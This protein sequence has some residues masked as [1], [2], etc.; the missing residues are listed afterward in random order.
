MEQSNQKPN[1]Y[2]ATRNIKKLQ[3]SIF[4]SLRSIYE[5]SIFVSEIS[6]IYPQLPLIANL[7]CGLWYNS[8]FESTCYFKSTDGHT[9]NW[10]FS[11]ARLN[12]HVAELAGQ[13]RG[14]M[15][16]D[17]TRKGKRFPDSMSKTIPIWC[18]VINRAIFKRKEK[19]FCDKELKY[20]S[21][22]WDCSLHLPLWV[23][24]TEKAAIEDRIEEWV[25]DLES[26]GADIDSVTSSLK[27]PLRPLWISQKSV[28]WLNEVPDCDSFDFT[29]IILVS[30]SA[31]H[32]EIQQ[33]RTSEF[34]WHYI[35]GAGDDEESWSRGLS[36]DLFWKHVYEI[37]DCG[38]ENCNQKV[39][40]IVEKERVYWSQRGVF[41][42]QVI[43]RTQKLG[44]QLLSDQESLIGSQPRNTK[45]TYSEEECFLHWIGETNVAVAR[46]CNVDRVSAS[47]DCILNCDSQTVTFSSSSAY[48]YLHLP[49][50]TS[51]LD[52]FSLLNGL[53][54]AID[55]AKLNLNKQRKL[56]VC[57]HD[58]EDISICVCLAIITAL[59][60]E[61]GCLDN[62]QYFMN[63]GIT[64]WEMRKRLVF[65]CKYAI[66]ARPSRGNLKQVFGFL[67]RQK[68]L[69]LLINET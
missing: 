47:V 25:N 55:F 9:N 53:S 52:R 56:L 13:R 20:I 51:K 11:T 1:I 67:N 50:L 57:C 32:G 54:R 22:T 42:P 40:E 14:C 7:R 58:G 69:H 59:F 4:N 29:P 21:D 18:C 49:V 30:A 26:C 3:N 64:K 65:V 46:S 66:N 10:S 31:T 15:I 48:S 41:S 37:I 36:P 8:K 28:I 12:L 61:K 16:V 23:S 27:K 24:S 17:S 60:D 38:P 44:G 62:G 2:K 39:S 43:V 35:P 63:S 6:N 5:D 68:D 33:R 45:I 19:D 34:S